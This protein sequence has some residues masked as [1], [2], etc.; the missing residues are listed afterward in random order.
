MAKNITL[1]QRLL[2]KKLLNEKASKAIIAEQTNVSVASIY[3]EL[4]RGTINGKYDPL[5][6]NNQSIVNRKKAGPKSSLS[7]DRS[8]ALK[9][10]HLIINEHL[11]PNEARNKLLSQGIYCPSKT[12]LY[13]AIHNGLIPNVTMESLKLTDTTMFSNGLIQ[14]P[15]H[16]RTQL[17]WNDKDKY[18]I[19][20][21]D[22]GIFIHKKQK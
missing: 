22:N 18:F 13:S 20:I 6:S 19:E 14:I 17:N 9:V 3:N 21:I 10:S 15:K 1:E 8:L 16:I 2:I 5:Y 4:K 11:S 12:T 7:I